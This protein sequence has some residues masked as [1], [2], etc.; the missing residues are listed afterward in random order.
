MTPDE[1]V[2]FIETG[3]IQCKDTKRRVRFDGL[4]IKE[5]PITRY[6]GKDGNDIET[7]PVDIE[8]ESVPDIFVFEVTVLKGKN[9]E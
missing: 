8:L 2:E 5:A 1:F 6:T 4:Y 7:E 3:T 9:K